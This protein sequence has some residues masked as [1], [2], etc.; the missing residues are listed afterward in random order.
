MIGFRQL[1]PQLNAIAINETQSPGSPSTGAGSSPA[2][3][4]Y[5]DGTVHTQH[6]TVGM[7][8]FTAEG[9]WAKVVVAWAL[10]G[11]AASS[12]LRD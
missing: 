3:T 2:I 12:L 6:G 10:S 11:S 1:R 8:N 9:G 5:L 7:T 4:H